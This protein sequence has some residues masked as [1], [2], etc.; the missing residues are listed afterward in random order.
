MI[1]W[2]WKNDH[3]GVCWGK[4]GE[5]EG[6]VVLAWLWLVGGGCGDI[7]RDGEV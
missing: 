2:G 6:G 5:V 1:N 3:W 7:V 4:R